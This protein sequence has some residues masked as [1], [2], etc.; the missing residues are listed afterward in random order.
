MDI[1][2][3]PV[4]VPNPEVFDLAA[5]IP[6]LRSVDW[7]TFDHRTLTERRA[8]DVAYRYDGWRHEQN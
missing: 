2:Q 6:D 7:Q 4:M 1:T 8:M 5:N 3:F